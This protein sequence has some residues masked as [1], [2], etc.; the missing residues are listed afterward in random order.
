[1]K[2]LLRNRPGLD[3]RRA[4]FTFTATDGDG[5]RVQLTIP[6]GDGGWFWN[7]RKGLHR[8]RGYVNGLR[9][10]KLRGGGDAWSLTMKGKDVAGASAVGFSGRR[11]TLTAG[12]ACA[13][14]APR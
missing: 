11:Y 12:G 9:L 14:E 7:P 10:V 4:D 3:P 8:W 5:D 2:G 13:T 6:A 1:M